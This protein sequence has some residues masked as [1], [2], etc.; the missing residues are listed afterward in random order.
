M[1]RREFIAL[2]GLG[3]AAWSR[4][5]SVKAA[6]RMR[7][8]VVLVPTPDTD[9]DGQGSVAALRRGLEQRG[10]VIGDNLA[11]DVR[12]RI[13]TVENA[14]SALDEILPLA[15]DVVIASTS[16]TVKALL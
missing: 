2:S 8:V 14:K 15:P 1:K 13:Q 16:Q 11:L 4:A 9:P 5:P 10:W 3:L 12:W 7:R 6:E